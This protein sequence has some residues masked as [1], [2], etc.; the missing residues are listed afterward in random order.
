MPVTSGDFWIVQHY[1]SHLLLPET[2]AQ[3]GL[4][5][6][7]IVGICVALKTLKAVQ[8]QGIIM[9]QQT[10]V[11]QRQAKAM[12]E[13]TKYVDGNIKLLYN[14]E[15]AW[16][17]LEIHSSGGTGTVTISNIGKSFA[18]V[19]S[20]RLV[21]ASYP[22]E[23][24]ELPASA[25]RRFETAQMVGRIVTA[26]TK[27]SFVQSFRIDDYVSEEDRAGTK[28]AVFCASVEYIDFLGVMPDSGLHTTEVCYS[29]KAS[30]GNLEYLQRYTK[31]S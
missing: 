6:A 18:K 23:V 12:E 17:D 11:L 19:I 24:I 26:N 4:M 21:Y 28:T 14:V 3:M 1:L 29:Y 5:I 2:L 30:T 7:G 20:F 8:R 25:T 27:D 13:Q 9:I 10:R 16:V 15:R 31:Y 22:L